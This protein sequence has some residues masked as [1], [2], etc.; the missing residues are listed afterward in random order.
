MKAKA[1]Y[2]RRRAAE[3]LFIF[4]LSLLFLFSPFVTYVT[5]LRSLYHDLDCL[6][7]YLYDGSGARGEGGAEDGC[8]L[9]ADS[10]VE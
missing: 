9:S 4:I 6:L 2:L 8:A 7:P 3:C 5:L 10:G 1:A